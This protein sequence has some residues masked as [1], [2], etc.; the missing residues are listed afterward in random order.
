MLHNS[1]PEN[2]LQEMVE[3]LFF[4]T[5][6]RKNVESLEILPL[7]NE[8]LR[9]RLLQTVQRDGGVWSRLRIAWHLPGGV[10]AAE[11][12]LHHGIQCDEEHCACGRYGLGGYVALSAAKA[13]AYADSDGAG[14]CRQLF[15]VVALP[16]ADIVKGERGIRPARTA[17][18][19]PSHPTDLCFVDS[20]RLYCTCLLRYNWVP[21]G[22]REK[23][24]TA[25]S[26]VSHV[27]SRTPSRGRRSLG[28]STRG[29]SQSPPDSHA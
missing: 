2:E 28:G 10:N 12:I 25:G 21:T 22:R 24:A 9:C 16:E 3:S 7:R 13:N 23:I 18:D 5:I 19:L 15:M 8:R 1:L 6:P 29:T 11:A 4:E 27:V 17:A 26:R 20:A 14:G